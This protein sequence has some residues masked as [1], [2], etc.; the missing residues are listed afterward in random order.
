VDD[1]GSAAQASECIEGAFKASGIFF[2]PTILT[3]GELARAIVD[4][5]AKRGLKTAIGPEA[6][7]TAIEDHVALVFES[8]TT[9]A[10][11]LKESFMTRLCENDSEGKKLTGSALERCRKRRDNLSFSYFQGLDGEG[12]AKPKF[13]NGRESAAKNNNGPPSTVDDLVQLAK[14]L[15]TKASFADDQTDYLERIALDIEIHDGRL[16]SHRQAVRAIGLLGGD[17]FDKIQLLT[18]LR[19]RF[20]EAVFFTTELDGRYVDG[21]PSPLIA[22]NLVVVSSFDLELE[23]S[24]QKF[25]PRFRSSEQ[26]AYFD[27]TLHALED[28]TPTKR[29]KPR[30][31][32][33]GRT[34]LFPLAAEKGGRECPNDSKDTAGGSDPES[35]DIPVGRCQVEHVLRHR[36]APVLVV[37]AA[38]LYLLFRSTR[39]ENRGLGGILIVVGLLGLILLGWGISNSVEP[40]AWLEGVS[41]WPTEFIRLGTILL[42]LYFLSNQYRQRDRLKT[43]PGLGKVYNDDNPPDFKPLEGLNRYIHPVKDTVQ[44][45]KS[46]WKIIG[47]ALILTVLG[48]FVF[49]LYFTYRHSGGNW[50]TLGLAMV[51]LGLIAFTFWKR[52]G[53][54]AEGIEKVWAYAPLLLTVS[55]SLMALFHPPTVPC[56]DVWSCIIDRLFLGTTIIIF[57]LLLST[58]L[59]VAREVHAWLLENEPKVREMKSPELLAMA[60]DRI[61]HETQ[62]VQALVVKPFVIAALMLV[63]RNRVFDNWVLSPGL[64]AIFLFSFGLMALCSYGVWE[65]ASRIRENKRKELRKARRM[66]ELDIDKALQSH[67]GAY[68]GILN[69]PI[70]KGAMLLAG[71]A[72]L[73]PLLAKILD[74]LG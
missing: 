16:H 33:V 7:S 44:I 53:N 71:G 43:K 47:Y 70:L 36:W 59:A 60:I 19:P 5:L 49:W 26:T 67:E 57:L 66:S 37:S 34:V 18:A 4:E 9:Y 12:V 1:L 38:G 54:G 21:T 32:E 8:D 68:G 25:I 28:R 74:F 30:L 11:N 23:Q 22:R 14:P 58:A 39:R 24:A 50:I 35:Y 41:I 46:N 27:A 48:L 55:L 10:R 3:D 51:S 13:N 72:G 56:R 61:G 62:K 63:S 15:A 42:G 64:L 45:I 2:K 65:P 29:M 20:P 69:G 31:F 40:F 17:V 52:E 6:E 73:E